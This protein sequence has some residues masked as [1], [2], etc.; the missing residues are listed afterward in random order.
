M[1]IL[2]NLDLNKNELQNAR[3][4]NLA[5]A[6]QNP[7]EGQI[8][9]NT[10]DKIIYQWDGEA[11]KAVGSDLTDYPTKEDVNGLITTAQ[12]TIGTEAT[13]V[14]VA[15][16]GTILDII[17]TQNGEQVIVDTD[18][19]ASAVVFSC[20]SAPSAEIVCKVVTAVELS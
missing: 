7:V 2:T 18:I 1:K 19:S 15:Y 5:T 3:V 6:P 17:A 13:S 4:Q 10:T 9:Y 16:T 8:Y 12:G 20:A 14:S 11:W